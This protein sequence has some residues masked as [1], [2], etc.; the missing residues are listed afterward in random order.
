MVANDFINVQMWSILSKESSVVNAEN[1]NVQ[2]LK[3]SYFIMRKKVLC[4]KK[5]C[6]VI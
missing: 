1:Q 4:Q 5:R 6:I 2:N 3:Y